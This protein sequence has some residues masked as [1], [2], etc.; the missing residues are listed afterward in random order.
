MGMINSF[1]GKKNLVLFCNG[2]EV[3]RSADDGDGMTVKTE[4][5]FKSPVVA[6]DRGR[7][8]HVVMGLANGEIWERDWE[9]GGAV[10]TQRVN[11][12]QPEVTAEAEKEETK[13]DD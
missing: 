13:D 9:D 2:A 10:Y 1:G 6:V 11:A 7:K 12:P 4:R 3:I 5:T 8:G